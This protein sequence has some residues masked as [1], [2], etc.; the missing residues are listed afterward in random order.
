VAFTV[1]VFNLFADVWNAGNTPAGGAPDFENVPVQLYISSRGTFDVQPCEMEQF[2]P[3]IWV[4]IPISEIAIWTS[5][6][7]WEVPA[8]TGRYYRARFKDVMHYGFSN[9]YLFAIVVQCNSEGIPLIRDIE[10]AE[11][12]AP[13]GPPS[14]AGAIDITVGVESNGE[15]TESGDAGPPVGAGEMN[16]F[17]NVTTTGEGSES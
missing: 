7:I 10:N 2:T 16:V 13:P 9:Q 1:P 12:C 11:P 4:R 15:G 8:E 5:G 17:V 14:G 6:Q 3:P